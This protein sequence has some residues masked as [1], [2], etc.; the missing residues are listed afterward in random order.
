MKK[1]FAAAV[2][3]VAVSA[4]FAAM[5]EKVT[6]VYVK[7]PFNLQNMVMKERGMLE[8]AFA[9]DG[10]RVEW[11]TITSGAKQGQAMAAGSV[12]VSAVMN[13]ASL[14][15][16]NGAGNPVLVA[17]GVAHPTDTFA[18][19]GRPGASMSVK[20]L[21]GKKVAG[22]RGT[23]LHQLLVA[24]LLKNGMKADDVEF[25]S[26]DPGSAMTALTS[27]RVDAAL[28]AASLII[29]A[30]DAGCKVITTAKGLVDVNLVMTA[31]KKFADQYPEAL[32]TVVKTEREAL[33]WINGN[34][35]EALKIGAKEHNI[36]LKDAEQLAKWSNYYSKVTEKDIKGLEA[37]QKFLLDN[38]L[39]NAP[40]DVRA[41]VLPIAL[42]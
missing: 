20:D 7:A 32:A 1:L 30:E 40:V 15:M 39:M 24:A 13:T 17:S 11:K 14:L 6:I 8:K 18:I 35:Q 33:D 27:G 22:P 36:S 23:V 29:K 12:D 41:L 10:V 34:W 31:S 37:D 3:A 38:K 2:L 4:A 21:K 5:P 28:L 9:K 25:I 26:M 19:V 16:A 42:K